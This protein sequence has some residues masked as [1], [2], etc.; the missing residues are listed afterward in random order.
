MNQTYFSARL[1][2]LIVCFFTTGN[3]FSQVGINTTTPSKQL[4]VDVR[5]MNNNGINITASGFNAQLLTATE[6]GTQKFILN[7]SQTAGDIDIRFNSTTRFGF[8]NS[9]LWPAVNA[10]TP[11][12]SGALD[13]GRFDRHYRRTYTRGVHTNDDD[14]NG[15]LGISIGSG[16]GSQSDY[17]FSDFAFYPVVSQLKDLGRNGNFWRNFYFVSAFTPSDS[18]LKNK[19]TPLSYGIET[20]QKMKVYEYVYTFEKT[21]IRHFGFMAQELKELVPEIVDTASNEEQSLSINYTEVIPILIK[22]VQEQQEMIDLQSQQ[23]EL[24][25]KEINLLKAK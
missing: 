20:L 9:A 16:G 25:K 19:I 7:N 15:G 13:L 12:V 21:G 3:I 5:G 8:S 11:F 4:D 24:L 6:S 23:I 22:S 17:I 2:L 14:V 10:T 1:A 18:R